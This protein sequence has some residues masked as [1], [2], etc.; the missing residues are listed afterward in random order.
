MVWYVSYGSNLDPDRLGTY[1][2]GGTP[3]GGHFTYQGARNA[4]P[5]QARRAAASPIVSTSPVS[6]ARGE[7]GSRSSTTTTSPRH[8]PSATPTW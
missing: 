7:A 2:S 6:P 4:T 1:L 3:T 8:P 5:P